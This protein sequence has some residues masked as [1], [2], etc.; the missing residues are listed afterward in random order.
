[1]EAGPKANYPAG[2]GFKSKWGKRKSNKTDLCE[3][4]G[5]V[6]Y[7]KSC[8]V[9]EEQGIEVHP[10]RNQWV[11]PF[12]LKSGERIPVDETEVVP[13]NISTDGVQRID[14][15]EN[16]EEDEIKTGR[17]SRKAKTSAIQYVSFNFFLLTLQKTGTG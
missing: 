9:N 3:R 4:M 14:V 1:M 7:S 13:D 5:T 15:E 17:P 6:P 12:R 8:Y 16:E 11:R 2:G 10:D